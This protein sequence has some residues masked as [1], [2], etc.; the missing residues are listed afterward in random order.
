MFDYRVIS[1]DKVVDGDTVDVTLDLGFYI[2]KR[3]RIRV[4]G[5]DTSELTSRDP[6]LRERAIQG[7]EF[8]RKW[9]SADL[10]Q[11]E[12]R[13]QTIKDKSDKYGRILGDFR[14]VGY[15]PMELGSSYSE[16]ILKSGLADPYS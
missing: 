4:L 15:S 13:V 16:A 8:A 5:I 2:Y 7:R 11:Y 3:E 6:V 10:S 14:Y 9:F 12:L 1:V